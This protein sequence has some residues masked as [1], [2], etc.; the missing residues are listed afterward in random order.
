MTVSLKTTTPTT[1][2]F[3]RIFGCIFL[4]GKR[5]I[6]C[7]AI[8]S[9]SGKKVLITGGNAGIGSEISKA[10]VNAGAQVTSL[11]RGQSGNIQ[12]DS[13]INSIYCDLS[14]PET[15]VMAVSK[16]SATFDI[17]ICN[18]GIVAH[19]YQQTP[20]GLE[21]TFATNVFGHHLLYRL[22]IEKGMIN[23][24]GKI[25]MTTGEA[26][27]S[28]TDCVPNASKYNKFEAYGGSKL[29]NLWQTRELVRHYPQFQ[30]IAVHPG[31]IA[32]G[33]GIQSKSGIVHWFRERLLISEKQGA[34]ASLIAATQPL[35]QGAY[36][37]NS[38]GL[39]TLQD[40]DVGSDE[41][42]SQLLWLTLESLSRPW[43]PN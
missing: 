38:K 4:Q 12:E 9:F 17:I 19:N 35:P 33:F 42:K 36:W 22:L 39:L 14:S 3:S 31:V 37:H 41:I 11:S 26:Y 40:E 29:G 23:E 43:L 25:I 13:N 30:S 1:N 7:P 5:Q 24:G 28:A 6:L 27:L 10:L 15:I 16:L 18:A 2:N 20:D 21:Q 8:E 32:S 34:Q